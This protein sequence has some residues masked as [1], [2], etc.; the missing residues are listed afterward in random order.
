MA[1]PADKLAESLDVLK[2]FQDQGRIA[3]R[4]G[5]LSRTHRQRLLTSGF[6]REVMKGW[7]IPSRPDEPQGD[8]TSWYASFWDFCATYLTERFGAAWCLSPE[9]SISV[10]TGD[11]TVPKQLLVR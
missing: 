7:Y 5:D 11:W 4:T 1:A 6:I 9:Q 8:S 2:S 10:H 3:I